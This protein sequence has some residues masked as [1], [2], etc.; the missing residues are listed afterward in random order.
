MAY[1][2]GTATPQRKTDGCAF[3]IFRQMIQATG[4]LTLAQVCS[5]T[6]LEP[7]TVQNWVKRGYVAHPINKRYYERQL[8]RILIINALRD[9]MQ[10]EQAIAV[11][12]FLN[13]DVEDERDDAIP[14]SRLFDYFC[15]VTKALSLEQGIS[16]SKVKESI[17]AVIEGFTG[18]HTD[19]AHKLY[20]AL[21]I[22]CYAHT[23]ARYK[24][25]AEL[26]FALI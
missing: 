5:I 10:I 17:A 12:K 3:D 6:N 25:E 8:A 1:V 24:R 21:E 23:A 16:R 2:P 4:G 18:Y 15:E 13:G 26:C 22:M 7:S 19:S 9:C 11:L 20:A 14:E